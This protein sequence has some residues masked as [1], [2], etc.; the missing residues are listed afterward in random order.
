M[1]NAQTG[2]F[3]FYNAQLWMNNAIFC[4]THLKI[5]RGLGVFSELQSYFCISYF[6]TPYYGESYGN[7][8]S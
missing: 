7:I 4:Y 5:Y 8:I 2:Q 1:K 3:L 6:K